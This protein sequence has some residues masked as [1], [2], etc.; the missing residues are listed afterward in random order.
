MITMIFVLHVCP[1]IKI[2]AGGCETISFFIILSGF[3]MAISRYSK[4]IKCTNKNIIFF[5]KNKIS[6]FYP[7]HL[8]M[9]LACVFLSMITMF[10][11][12]DFHN[13]NLLIK[14]FISQLFLIQAFVPN[15]DIYFGLNGVS[16]YLSATLFFYIISLPVLNLLKKIDNNKVLIMIPC[17]LLILHTV[18]IILLQKNINFSFLTYIFP[19]FRSLE[20]ISGMSLGIL[21][22]KEK[23][24]INNILSFKKS[25]ILEIMIIVL[26]IIQ[27]YLCSYTQIYNIPYNY[28]SPIGFLISLAIVIIFSMEKGFI[29]KILSAKLFVYIGN[30]SFEIYIM[31]TVIMNYCDTF[32]EILGMNKYKVI[33][34]L[35]VTLILAGFIH[36]HPIKVRKLD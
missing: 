11:S 30:I 34:T 35:I 1:Q 6:K 32:L 31:H 9:L 16:W 20:F 3:V 24:N 21:Y 23:R 2:L 26:F 25:T 15:S 27:R 29:S 10:L 22:L 12:K 8:L 19:L 5:V 28:K 7:L 14:Q 4:D 17:I 36:S 13:M 18:I 33:L